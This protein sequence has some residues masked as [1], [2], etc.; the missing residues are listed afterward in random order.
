MKKLKALLLI[1]LFVFVTVTAVTTLSLD[2]IP[3]PNPKDA[4]G[5]WAMVCCGSDCK[6]GIDYCVGD[7]SYKCCK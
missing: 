2:A 6:N 7:G 5:K 4:E 1:I 3:D